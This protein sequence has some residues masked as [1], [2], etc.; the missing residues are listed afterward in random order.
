[1]ANVTE[2]LL[3]F[4]LFNSPRGQVQSWSVAPMSLKHYIYYMLSVAPPL[5]K[6][7]LWGVIW[8]FLWWEGIASTEL[9][10]LSKLSDLSLL[11][12]N[13]AA[14]SFIVVKDHLELWLCVKYLPSGCTSSCRYITQSRITE[15]SF[16][17][18]NHSFVI[19]TDHLELRLCMSIRAAFTYT[20]PRRWMTQCCSALWAFHI[21]SYYEWTISNVGQV[22][23][24]TQL[25]I[26]D[27]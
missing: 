5:L 24:I 26:A 22:P 13:N 1:M 9:C 20:Q 6:P 25:I 2:E 18:M 17:I 19:M 14:C 11:W 3:F 4:F 21:I 16:T 12:M 23:C 10:S 15:W 7:K 8:V 27:S